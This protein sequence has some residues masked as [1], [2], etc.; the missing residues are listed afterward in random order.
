MSHT[1]YK[2]PDGAGEAFLEAVNTA[3]ERVYAAIRRVAVVRR[4]QE[5]FAA[6]EVM[7]LESVLR[8]FG[9]PW[10]TSEAARAFLAR[11][12]RSASSA[13]RTAELEF[14]A[15][16]AAARPVVFGIEL[17]RY[18]IALAVERLQLAAR[19]VEN[20]ALRLTRE[21][22]SNTRGSEKWYG[23]AQPNCNPPPLS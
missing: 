20:E 9:E 6:V 23:A 17:D 10:Q 15:L 11:E 19:D 13:E 21:A 12:M 2:L 5:I 18:P 14:A 22:C 16:S 4:A 7:A 8:V 3:K 1:D